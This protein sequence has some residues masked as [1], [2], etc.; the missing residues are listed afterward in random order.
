MVA[1]KSLSRM[2]LDTLTDRCREETERFFRR[3]AYVQ[4]YCIELFRRAIV[5]RDEM[6]WN[7]VYAQYENLVRGWVKQH[8]GMPQAGEDIQYFV[9]RAFEKMWRAVTPDKFVGFRDL[10]SL[11]R[12]L[13]MCVH[14]VIV[15]RLRFMEA[16]VQAEAWDELRSHPNTHSDS[17]EDR[18]LAGAQKEALWR[19]IQEQLRDDTEEIVIYSSFI[20]ALKPSQIITEYPNKFTSVE[21]VYRAKQNVLNRLRRNPE[22]ENFL[23]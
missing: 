14:S 12:Y 10:K 13:Q 20:L 6:A 21:Q 22:M 7:G 23:S 11:L 5:D 3:L 19:F 15:D 4:S 1:T 16:K 8:S 18:A 2:P 9:N 17:V